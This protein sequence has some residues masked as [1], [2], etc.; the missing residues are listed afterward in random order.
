MLDH[1]SEGRLDV[2]TGRGVS[3]AEVGFYGIDQAES[4]PRY[5][6]ALEVITKGLTEERLTHHGSYFRYDDVPMVMKPLQD[7]LPL[8]NAAMAPEGQR[9]A[10]RHRMHMIGLGATAEIKRAVASYREIWAEHAGDAARPKIGTAS[11]FMGAYRILVVGKTDAHAEALARPAFRNWFEKLIK[12]W[13]EHNITP[14]FLGSLGTYEAAA[15][16]GM[17]IVGSPAR[18]ID[19]L[20]AQIELCGLNY[21]MLQLAFG[22]LPH[23]EEL[24]SLERFATEVMPAF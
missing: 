4:G 1:L 5:G 16:A 2:G 6:E 3:P 8:W 21:L 19:A 11:P 7:P 13:R 12:L 18:V 24:R 9:Y 15:A 14:R 17:L 10:V 22:N 23:R 20:A